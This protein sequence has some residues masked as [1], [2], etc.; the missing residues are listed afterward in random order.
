MKKCESLSQELAENSVYGI[1][2]IGLDGSFLCANQV[3]LKILA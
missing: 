3:L 1:F 2:R